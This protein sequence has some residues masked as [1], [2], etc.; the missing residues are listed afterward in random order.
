MHRYPAWVKEVHP[1]TADEGAES[2]MHTV[3]FFGFGNELMV[4]AASIRAVK[5]LEVIRIHENPRIHESTNLRIHESTNPFVWRH[6][7]LCCA[8]IERSTLAPPGG[9]VSC[10]PVAP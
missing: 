6:W 4:G 10:H 3:V 7:R 5:P 2:V 9:C 8:V 1:A